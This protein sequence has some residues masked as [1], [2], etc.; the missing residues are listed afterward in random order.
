MKCFGKVIVCALLP[1]SITANAGFYANTAHSR[2]NCMGFNESITWNWSEYHWWEVEA[3][4]FRQKGSGPNTHRLKAW[5][6]YTW[7]AAALDFWKD[8][9]GGN[10]DQYWVQGYH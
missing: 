6:A 9:A 8:P 3:I 10:A 4:H 2:G 7:R 5:M 1:A